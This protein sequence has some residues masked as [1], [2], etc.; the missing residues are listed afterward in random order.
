MF[1]EDKVL[2]CKECGE[3]F[4][5]TA[6]EQEFYREKGFENNPSRCPA[7]RAARKQRNQQRG[8]YGRQQVR[9][10]H[11]A[12]CAQCGAETKVPFVPSQDR[13][14]YCRDCYQEVRQSRNRR[15][16]Y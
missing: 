13:P 15:Y 11:S 16:A 12:V 5:F 8:D 4:V 1:F 9:E 6:R 7:C 10:L 14:V 2:T 3:D